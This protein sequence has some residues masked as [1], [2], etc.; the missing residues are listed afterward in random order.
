MAL[1]P[2]A[3]PREWRQ[4]GRAAGGDIRRKSL[5][6]MDGREGHD[7]LSVGYNSESLHRAVCRNSA[8]CQAMAARLGFLLCLCGSRW[9]NTGRG[10][11]RSAEPHMAG[12]VEL[13]GCPSSTTWLPWPIRRAGDPCHGTQKVQRVHLGGLW[14]LYPPGIERGGS[15]RAVRAAGPTAK[16]KSALPFLR[17]KDKV[18]HGHSVQEQETLYREPSTPGPDIRNTKQAHNIGTSQYAES[19]TKES[20]IYREEKGPIQRP[21]HR[22]QIIMG[23]ILHT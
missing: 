16:R 12:R 17:R 5:H 21:T 13:L 20:P 14:E 15:G 8:L 23:Y 9:G 22:G 2:G 6:R 10:V 11:P 1:S 7:E 19:Y 18:G 4:P 3:G